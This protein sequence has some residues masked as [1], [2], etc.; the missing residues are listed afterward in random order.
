MA[1]LRRLGDVG[2]FVLATTVA[3]G[4]SAAVGMAALGLGGIPVTG[5]LLL[6]WLLRNGAAIVIIAGTGLAVRGARDLVHRRHLVEA[7]PVLV[8]SL[9]VLWLVFGPG[10]SISLSF[11]PLAVLVWGGLRLPIPLAALQGTTT[12]VV[13][14]ALA[15]AAEVSSPFGDVDEVAGSC[16]RSRRS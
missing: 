2:R 11:L 13:T 5:E 14:L 7:V 4:A 15:V 10:R 1:P 6:G 12:A 16:S 9:A 8:A 3:T